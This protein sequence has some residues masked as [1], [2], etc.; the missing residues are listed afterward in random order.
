MYGLAWTWRPGDRVRRTGLRASAKKQPRRWPTRRG[1]VYAR[2]SARR[3]A[4]CAADP[5]QRRRVRLQRDCAAAAGQVSQGERAGVRAAAWSLARSPA[6]PAVPAWVRACSLPTTAVPCSAPARCC[7]ARCRRTGAL[8]EVIPETEEGDVDLV[9]L[10]GMLRPGGSAGRPPALVSISHV[11]T[12]SGGEQGFGTHACCPGCHED[13]KHQDIFFVQS[14][15]HSSRHATHK[16]ACVLCGRP[17]VR[18]C[19]RGRVVPR[20]GRALHAGRLPERGP[21]ARRRACHRLRLSVGHGA[22]VP[23]RPARLWPA[24]LPQARRRCSACC[25]AHTCMQ[26]RMHS[27]PCPCMP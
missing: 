2:P 1:A 10:Q 11:P 26:G 17:R 24:L 25:A 21:D 23:A 12:S 7:L 4:P 14:R 9:A 15:L 13:S 22:Q 19:Q 3:L 16:P 18:R 5:D 8:V 20:R 6:A 27:V